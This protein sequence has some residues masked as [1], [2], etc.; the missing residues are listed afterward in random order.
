M[1]GAGGLDRSRGEGLPNGVRGEGGVR[2]LLPAAAELPLRDQD[3]M[4]LAEGATH[5]KLR[6]GPR[7]AASGVKL[8]ATCRALKAGPG[9]GVCDGAFQ[10]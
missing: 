4:R 6:W 10:L 2:R 5:A 3:R 7:E 1:L 8:R 9:A